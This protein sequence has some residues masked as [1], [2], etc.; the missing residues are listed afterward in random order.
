MAESSFTTEIKA[1]NE[2]IAIFYTADDKDLG[3][4]GSILA[5]LDEVLDNKVLPDEFVAT[6]E[7]FITNLGD[8]M[9]SGNTAKYIKEGPSLL[10]SLI[11]L[12][13]GTTELEVTSE[14]S[15]SQKK[16]AQENISIELEKIEELEDI[17]LKLDND[18]DGAERYHL[19]R[20]LHSLKGDLGVLGLT[21]M[22][23]VVHKV[24]DVVGELAENE[25]ETVIPLL[26]G[27]KDLMSLKI[28][29]VMDGN[30][31]DVTQK[32]YS[33]ILGQF[34]VQDTGKVVEPS[35][36]SLKNLTKNLEVTAEEDLLVEFITEGK[37]HVISAESSLIELENNPGDSELINAAFRSC[38]TI[39]GVAGFMNLKPIQEFAHSLE[40]IMDSVRMGSRAMDEKLSTLLL[41]GFDHLGSMVNKVEELL[42]SG[43][44]EISNEI[45]DVY[46][47][48]QRMDENHVSNTIQTSDPVEQSEVAV[49]LAEK[50][51]EVT[52]SNGF[53]IVD[54]VSVKEKEIKNQQMLSS[55][56]KKLMTQSL[57][58]DAVEDE[59]P[60]INKSKNQPSGRIEETVRVSVSR[61]DQL[62]DSIGEIVIAQSM[63]TAD[64]DF[65]RLKTRSIEQKASQISMVMRQIQEEA[66]S[67]RM[68][69]LKSTFQKMTRL[70]RDLSKKMDKP[71]NLTIT[72]EDTELDKS[73]IEH[74]GDPLV[75]MLRNSVDH[76][77]ET[78]D[79]RKNAHKKALGEVEL[80]AYHKSGNVVID[81]IDD[82]RGLNK[83]LL[84]KKAI[85]NGIANANHEY[86]EQEIFQFIFA[87]GF[88]TA[89]E[90][91][92][93]SGRGVGMDVVKRNIVG[94]RGSLEIASEPGK[95][96]CFSIKL[97]LTMAII[98]GMIVT[99]GAES[100]IL[101]TLSIITTVNPTNDQ[102]QSVRGKGEM[103]KLHDHLYRFIRLSSLLGLEAEV[104]DPSTGI[105]IL[106]EDILG[107]RVALWVDSIVKKQQVVIKS[108]GQLF[109]NY[110]WISGGAVLGNGKVNLILDVNELFKLMEL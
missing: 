70:V 98:D 107:N 3:I 74:I 89:S 76:G 55:D 109:Q 67:L 90:I 52:S 14:M 46:H 12:I 20:L 6:L 94:M 38:H 32:E 73:I 50:Y 36:S 104:K 51:D 62:I 80:R 71:I 100:L 29:E 18:N 58:D 54:D 1:L 23:L 21:S 41:T 56:V 65:V 40:N 93:V 37:E 103:L 31:I 110:K 28:R 82:G 9:L 78:P 34:L 22:V 83:D 84:M 57:Q 47:D 30:F 75:H 7:E 42:P 68:V 8:A 35:E 17:V 16:F 106:I 69:S 79:E 19:L 2:C 108:M 59:K 61:L 77:L 96:T 48:L 53:D 105:A 39:K 88:S 4:L 64:P 85:E 95:G 25:S 97:P 102:I 5:N 72:G 43:Q 24:E 11:S 81:I 45:N 87:P 33:A 26:L 44:Y 63:L 49:E 86:T 15:E 91:T 92:D 101:P 99:A 66:M 27:F 10:N 60:S 13:G